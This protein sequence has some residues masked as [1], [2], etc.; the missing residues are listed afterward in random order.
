MTVRIETTDLF[1]IYGSRPQEALALAARG[2]TARQVLDETQQILAVS[3]VSFQVMEGEIFTI[4]GLSGSGKSTLVRCLN[5]LI[6]PTAGSIRIDGQELL[7]QSVAGLRSTRRQKIAMVFQNFALLPHM[8][9]LENTE[10]GLKL[11]GESSTER[12]AKSLKALEQVGLADWGNRYPDNLSGGMKQRVGLARALAN[13]PDILLM[14]EPFSA[15]D[16]LIRADLQ[17]ELLRLQRE[18]RKTIVFITHDFHEAVRL[19]DRVAIMRD[20]AFVQVGTPEEIVINPSD[21][22]VANFARDMDRSRL[23]TAREVARSTVPALSAAIS[24]SEA[25]AQM[26]HA[27]KSCTI[28]V[29]HNNRPQFYLLRSD[30]EAAGSLEGRSAYEFRRSEAIRTAACGSV[31]IDLF[32]SFKHHLPFAVI[33]DAGAV[34]GTM[35]ANDVL[36]HLG[37]VTA[38]RPA[39]QTETTKTNK[40]LLHVQKAN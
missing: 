25:L 32:P 24:A 27:G 10:F 28:A 31:L 12:R 23:M 39:S 37:Q 22:Y 40:P 13:D 16:P 9:V 18:I 1:K 7:T 14:D 21:H 6:E 15:L 36:V 30:L 35:D 34:I 19:S 8:T 33:D 17:N 38:G 4:M 20:G 29:D 26:E 2:K 11:R 5:R 3:N